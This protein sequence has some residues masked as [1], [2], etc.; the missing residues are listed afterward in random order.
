MAPSSSPERTRPRPATSLT[1]RRRPGPMFPAPDQLG[2]D[3]VLPDF[4]YLR[5]R[6]ADIEAIVLTHGHEDH[7][8]AL[9]YVLREL[10]PVAV[11]P[12]Y[13]GALTTE[14]VRSKLDEHRLGDVADL[15]Q[16]DPGDPLDAGPFSIETVRLSHSIPDSCGVALGCELGTLLVTGDYKFDQTPVDGPP[17]DMARLAEL[18]RDG[19]LLLC[20][21]STDVDRPGFSPSEAIVGPRLQELFMGCSGRI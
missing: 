21:D 20:G 1:S 19:L 3:L 12:V 13:G 6:A 11:P 14:L 8:G 17:A 18:G 10:A 4:A 2:I 9:P 16:V 15:R 5:E 7:V